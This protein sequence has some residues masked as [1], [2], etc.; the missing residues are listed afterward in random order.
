MFNTETSNRTKTWQKVDTIQQLCFGASGNKL[1]ELLI[2]KII[3]QH[4]FKELT[5]TPIVIDKKYETE[6]PETH[7]LS[8]YISEGIA[9]L[10]IFS[11]N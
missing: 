5:V 11:R 7:L 3:I 10:N 6:S 2:S 1:K 4:I 8:L 9:N